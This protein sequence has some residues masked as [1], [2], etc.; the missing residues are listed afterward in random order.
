MPW[1]QRTTKTS[2]AVRTT[3]EPAASPPAHCGLYSNAR[4]PAPTRSLLS[5]LSIGEGN[6]APSVLNPV[7]K[8][9]ILHRLAPTLTGS[10]DAAGRALKP[11]PPKSGYR[12]AQASQRPIF[13]L[14][15]CC[16]LLPTRRERLPPIAH[17]PQ[18]AR[19]PCVALSA[20]RSIARADRAGTTGASP[21]K[22]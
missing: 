6:H 14:R 2:P 15:V 13:V 8:G 21:P 5:G 22:G 3:V 18:E 7:D 1:P 12:Y 10:K 9:R 20:L 17:T 4:S 11:A 19:V 16:G